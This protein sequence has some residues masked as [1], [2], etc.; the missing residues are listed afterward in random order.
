MAQDRVEPDHWLWCEVILQ[1][2]LRDRALEPRDPP[3]PAEPSEV[4]GDGA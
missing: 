1:V 3:D 2:Q 4:V